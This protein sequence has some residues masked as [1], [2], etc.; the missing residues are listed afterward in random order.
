MVKRFNKLFLIL[1]CI[2]SMIIL[3]SCDSF[4]SE[5]EK[6]DSMIQNFI[7]KLETNEISE[8]K[9]I[10]ANGKVAD[11]EDFDKSIDELFEYYQGT[12]VSRQLKTKGQERDKDY[13]Y[14]ASWYVISCDIVTTENSYRMFFYW[15]TE[16]TTNSEMIGI[17]SFYIIKSSDDTNP[18]ISYGGDSLRIPG[19]N[20]GKVYVRDETK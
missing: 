11:L 13:D 1:I 14:Q 20:I 19:I 3:S 16:Y 5:E 15:C 18:N 8:I 7:E 6:I 17:W 2:F 9:K 4:L 10:F 12:C